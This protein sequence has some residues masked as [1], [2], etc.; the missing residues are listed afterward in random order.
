MRD[1]ATRPQNTA[2]QHRQR[3]ERCDYCR[4][5]HPTVSPDT[6]VAYCMGTLAHG[7]RLLIVVAERE[8][9]AIVA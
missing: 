8:R 4:R 7:P 9:E 2:Q 6:R 5:V 1:I 3:V